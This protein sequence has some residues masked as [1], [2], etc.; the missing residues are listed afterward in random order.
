MKE[1]NGKIYYTDEEIDK[2]HKRYRECKNIGNDCNK[3][4]FMAKHMATKFCSED[5][6]NKYS[7]W[8]KQLTKKRKLCTRKNNIRI[9]TNLMQNNLKPV[10]S[11]N[12]LV[13]M[14]FKFEER[15]GYEFLPDLNRKGIVFENFIL[16]LWEKDK[17][18]ITKK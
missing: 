13:E 4:E 1:Q 2:N 7:N 12:A 3:H 10:V 5:C 18:L 9:L 16:I 14:N 8:E 17:F 11:Y 6:N 15:N